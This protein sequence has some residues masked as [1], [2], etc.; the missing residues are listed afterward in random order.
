MVV[1]TWWTDRAKSEKIGAHDA[2][3]ARAYDMSYIVN[4]VVSTENEANDWRYIRTTYK[5]LF[6]FDRMEALFI[7]INNSNVV[8][9]VLHTYTQTPQKWYDFLL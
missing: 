8:F 9:T 7:G 5:T 3:S 4:V 6:A 2:W 1:C